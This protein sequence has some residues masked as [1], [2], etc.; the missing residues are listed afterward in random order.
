M[1]GI[2]LS[3]PIMAGKVEAWRRLCQELSVSRLLMYEASRRLQGITHERLAL[4]ETAYGAA[5]VTTLEA[6]NI[7]LALGGLL[8]SDSPFDSWYR[9]QLQQLHGVSLARYEQYAMPIPHPPKQELL[10]VWTSPA[11]TT[12]D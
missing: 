3:V 12:S 11:V 2:V 10:F 8:A 6:Q 7:G 5:A 4:V 1:S 9:E